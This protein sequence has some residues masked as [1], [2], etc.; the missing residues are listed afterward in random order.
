MRFSLQHSILQ[1]CFKRRLPKIL[2]DMKHYLTK[3]S[4]SINTSTND[5]RTNSCFD[6]ETIKN[7]LK[8]KFKNRIDNTRSRAWCDIMVKDYTGTWLP[9]NIKSTKIDSAI[10]TG[11]FT[12]PLQAFTNQ[13]MDELKS[14]N[15]GFCSKL[16]FEKLKN[17]EYNTNRLKDYYF[18]VI[19]KQNTNDIIINSVLGINTFTRNDNNPPFQ[20]NFK[21]NRT[22]TY[23]L[24]TQ[25]IQKFIML[26]SNS[27]TWWRYRWIN[28][29]QTLI[30]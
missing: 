17:K 13:N 4:I 14:Y 19:N 7:L 16:L 10:N 12:L 15:N 11:N 18:L 2:Y 9:V 1:N 24:I 22:Y 3:Q 27:H 23:H 28:N 6:E 25:Q 30:N 8:I 29:I 20:I 21:K 26:W 5:G